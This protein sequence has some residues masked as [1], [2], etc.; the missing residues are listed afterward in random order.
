M[1]DSRSFPSTTGRV[2]DAQTANFGTEGGDGR[3]EKRREERTRE[4]KN[5]NQ[6]SGEEKI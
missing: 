5:R 3:Q 2:P 1:N 6:T 4:D